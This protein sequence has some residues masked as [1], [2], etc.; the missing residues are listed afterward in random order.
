MN[1]ERSNPVRSGMTL[2]EVLAALAILVVLSAAVIGFFLSAT[3]RRDQLV[4]LASQER[5]CAVLLDRLESSLLTAVAVAPDGSAGVRGGP[6]SL[7]V[8]SRGVTGALPGTAALSDATSLTFEFDEASRSCICTLEV[9]GADPVREVVA[10]AIERMRFRYSNGRAW[11]TDFDTLSSGGLPA[12]VEVSIWLEP[13]AGPPE[14]ADEPTPPETPAEGPGGAG[15]GPVDF[16]PPGAKPEWTPRE[17]DHVRV[18][19]VPDAPSWKEAG[20]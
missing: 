8:T 12:A 9:D 16:A 4:K 6:T 14:G 3:S 5:E 18:L 10:S 7:A 11:S 19:V 13:R 20:T 1:P 2:I 17:P 15:L